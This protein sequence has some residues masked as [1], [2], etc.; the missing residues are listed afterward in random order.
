MRSRWEVEMWGE[1]GGVGEGVE[2]EAEAERKGG[3]RSKPT[4][5]GEQ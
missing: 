3:Q 4:K 2:E 5:Q 1:E